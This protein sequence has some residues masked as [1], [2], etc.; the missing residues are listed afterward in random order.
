MGFCRAWLTDPKVVP[1]SPDLPPSVRKCRGPDGSC[2][3]DV[4]NF[5][6]QKGQSRSS[7]PI[8]ARRGVRQHVLRP[9]IIVTRTHDT[10]A[11]TG[12]TAPSKDTGGVERSIS[13]CVAIK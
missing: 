2:Q 6:E 3:R 4:V 1:G 13:A 11:K 8:R 12:S 5:S 9:F 10:L 7:G